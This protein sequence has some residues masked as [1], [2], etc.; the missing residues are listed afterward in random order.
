MSE[1]T[2][3]LIG[4]NI[5]EIFIPMPENEYKCVECGPEMPIFDPGCEKCIEERYNKS[6]LNLLEF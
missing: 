6:E 4:R 2:N 1:K 5:T 3:S